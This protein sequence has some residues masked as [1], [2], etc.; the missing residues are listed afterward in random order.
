MRYSKEGDE[1]YHKGTL[2]RFSAFIMGIARNHLMVIKHAIAN[3]VGADSIVYCDT[4]SVFVSFDKFAPG[5][6]YLA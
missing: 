3:I 2:V 4:D 5:D 1:L 6:N